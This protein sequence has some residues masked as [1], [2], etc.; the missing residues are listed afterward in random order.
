MKRLCQSYSTQKIKTLTTLYIY[1][2]PL[3]TPKNKTWNLAQPKQS[4]KL[5]IK[6]CTKVIQIRAKVTILDKEVWES[7]IM[8]YQN[9]GEFHQRLFVGTPI[10]I[11]QNK[12]LSVNTKKTSHQLPHL[13]IVQIGPRILNRCKYLR[14]NLTN[15]FL[16]AT[17][18][19]SKSKD[20]TRWTLPAMG[21]D[22]SSQGSANNLSK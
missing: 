18:V 5:S 6:A 11:I 12:K 1:K 22:I 3:M 13:Q 16:Y 8:N 21:L 17:K 19:S 10:T 9:L 7:K 20:P 14:I 15:K 4:A 2:D